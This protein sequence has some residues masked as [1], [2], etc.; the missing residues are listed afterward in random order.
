MSKSSSK[1]SSPKDDVAISGYADISSKEAKQQTIIGIIV[2]I[3]I[4]AIVGGIVAWRVIASHN[5]SSSTEQAL[6]TAQKNI[7]SSTA[8]K[9]SNWIAKDGAIVFNK[10]GIVEHPDTAL[11]D[12]EKKMKQVDVYLDLNCPGCGAVDRSL[13]MYYQQYL[14]SGKIIL[15]MHPIAFLDATSMGDHYST[16][17]ANSVYRLLDI[18]PSAVYSYVTYLFSDG[19]QPGEG[20]DYKKFTDE[21]LISAARKVG[22][23]SDKVSELT[24]KKYATY[25]KNVTLSV[26]NN[27]DLWRPNAQQFS[28]P[29]VTIDGKQLTFDT[30]GAF[31]KQFTTAIVG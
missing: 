16:R 18:D 30:S 28:T 11:T 31:V 26:V 8:V 23:T 1:K 6:V 5:A 13:N 19:V 4:V 17:S 24:D 15:R 7:T 10:N 22:V 21:M 27:T 3:L 25:V 9:P 2:V 12:S 29:V 14:S 20:S